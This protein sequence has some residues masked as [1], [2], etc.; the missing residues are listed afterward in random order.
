MIET[1]RYSSSMRVKLGVSRPS[2]WA[3]LWACRDLE[4]SM[5]QVYT[6]QHKF[7]H[8]IYYNE[9]NALDLSL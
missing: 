3:T 7:S 8:F 9:E 1:K 2:S 5:T 6:R 4:G